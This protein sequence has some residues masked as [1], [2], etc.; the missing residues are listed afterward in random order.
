MKVHLIG[1]GGIGVSALAQYYLSKGY[2][3][4]GSDLVASEITDFLKKKEWL[5]NFMDNFNTEIILLDK[6]GKG[7][8]KIINKFKNMESRI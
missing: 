7:R 3:V 1:I 6:I 2:E 8:D 4:S 5:I